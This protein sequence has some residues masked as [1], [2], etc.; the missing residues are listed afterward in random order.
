M[1]SVVTP[2]SSMSAASSAGV[3]FSINSAEPPARSGK[4]RSPPRPKVNAIGGV[5]VK[6]SSG[7]GR[8]TCAEKV[9]AIASTSRWKCIAHLGRP[10]VPEVK[11]SRAT[12][13]AEVSTSAKS[14]GRSAARRVRSSPDSP[15]KVTTGTSTPSI[16]S[17]KRWSTSA[18]SGAAISVITCSSWVRS[19][20]I[21]ATTTPPA[22]R[23]PNQQATSHGL[24]GPRSS[25]RLPGTRPWSSTSTCAIRLAAARRSSYV[26][27]G[28][29][30]ACRQGRSPPRSAIVSS[31]SAVAQFRRS[32]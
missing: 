3:A 11:A 17:R 16:G 7:V 27:G 5:P 31:S 4:T 10:V 26:Q 30:F 23:T 25:T 2:Y 28:A 18:R 6:T 13:S 21:V 22:L 32:G 29:P 19:N 9:S 1:K 8:R 15:P 12:S 20:G 14:V 24:F